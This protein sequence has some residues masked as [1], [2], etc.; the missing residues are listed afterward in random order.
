MCHENL[1]SC[2]HLV[3]ARQIHVEVGA[4]ELCLLAQGSSFILMLISIP[5][6]YTIKMQKV[7]DTSDKM[8]EKRK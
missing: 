1:I 8:I 7:R 2:L 6:Y 4:Y 5:Q 3:K